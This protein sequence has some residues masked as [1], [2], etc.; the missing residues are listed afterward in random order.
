MGKGFWKIM[1]LC[2]RTMRSTL[3]LFDSFLQNLLSLIPGRVIFFLQDFPPM[4]P[5]QQQWAHKS[6][7]KFCGNYNNQ[8][9]TNHCSNFLLRGLAA[10]QGWV[11]RA[12]PDNV[13]IISFYLLKQSSHISKAF[14]LGFPRK[15]EHKLTTVSYKNINPQLESSL[16]GFFS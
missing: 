5:W 16:I 3:H 10:Y 2:G 4:Q 15:V 1:T 13:S 7:P 8:S 11:L 14:Q 9:V 12:V 6:Q